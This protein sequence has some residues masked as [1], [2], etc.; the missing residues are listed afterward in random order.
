M[1]HGAAPPNV[2]ASSRTSRGTTWRL[3]MID[4]KRRGDAFV[5]SGPCGEDAAAL[6]ADRCLCDVLAL[7]G[8]RPI[9]ER[10]A[11]L[12]AALVARAV[13][14]QGMDAEECER[15]RYLLDHSCPEGGRGP[16]DRGT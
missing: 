6:A 1:R 4:P 10:E 16:G 3:V 9:G 7:L 13:A 15:L 2:P 12:V 8:R 11:G 14:G 5:P